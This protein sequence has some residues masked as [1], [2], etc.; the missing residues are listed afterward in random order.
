MSSIPVLQRDLFHEFNTHTLMADM[1]D[2]QMERWPY[3]INVPG[4]GNGHP[5][6]QDEVKRDREGEL[7]HITYRQ[8]NGVF[9]LCIYND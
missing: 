2:T 3:A 4:V 9:K 8:A 1:S 6:V 5:F 7:C